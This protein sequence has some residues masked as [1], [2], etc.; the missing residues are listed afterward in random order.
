MVR[1][2]EKR[3]RKY[4]AKVDGETLAKQTKALKP[5]MV[6]GETEYFNEIAKLEAK[7]K[8][9]VE[10]EGVSTLHVRDYLNYAREIFSV[11]KRFEAATRNVEAQLILNK[12]QNRGLN[13]SLLVK[14]ARLMGCDPT[15]APTVIS[16][17]DV[18]DRENRELGKTTVKNFPSEYPLPSSQVSDLKSVYVGN[19]P[20]EYPLPT[21]QVSDLKNIT[22]TNFPSEITVKQAS[23]VNLK[24]QTEREDLISYGGVASPNNA[25]VLIVAGETGKKIKVYDAGYEAGVDGLHYFYFGTSTT[26]TNKRFC[27]SNKAGL[28][29]KTFSHPRVGDEGDSLYLFSSVQETNMPY[30]IG[31]V[32]E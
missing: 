9:L 6:E 10:T 8:G 18:T 17:V 12:W 14:I 4:M 5:L 24:A 22:V 3:K 13:G 31:Y 21:S 28:I 11:S 30:D 7:V 29:H 16:Q 25:G 26:P 1:G 20:T 19:F 15:P 27:T 23:R 2:S 32:K